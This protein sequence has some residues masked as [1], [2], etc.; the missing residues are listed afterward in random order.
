MSYDFREG[1]F[2][3]FKPHLGKLG[4]IHRV[5]GTRDN[6]FQ[7]YMEPLIP[8]PQHPWCYTDYDQLEPEPVSLLE[9]LAE[10]SQ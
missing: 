8:D 6:G 4:K 10:V 5:I 1:H 9:V 3:R 7:V 2:V